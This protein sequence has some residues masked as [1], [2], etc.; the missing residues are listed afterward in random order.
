MV[1]KENA[2]K[3]IFLSKVIDEYIS[4]I[5]GRNEVRVVDIDGKRSPED[6]FY[7][8]KLSPKGVDNNERSS[9]TNINQIGVDFIIKQSD[10]SKTIIKVSPIGEFYYRV[11]P[12]LEEQKNAIEERDKI[13]QTK[14]E[15]KFKDI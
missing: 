6:R 13:I 12:T 4:K 5:T 10:L 11:F 7:V 14:R 9:K 2:N 15:T 8:G 1:N 3:A